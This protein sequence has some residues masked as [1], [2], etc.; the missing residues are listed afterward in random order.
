[1][2]EVL[3]PTISRALR[4]YYRGPNHPMKLRFWGWFRRAFGYAPLTVRYCER[5]WLT[6][7]ERD[8]VQRFVFTTGFYEPEVWNSL[9]TF[10]SKNEVVWDIGAHVGT[11]TIRS[12]WDSRVAAVRAFEPDPDLR[13]TLERNVRLNSRRRQICSVHGIAVAAGSRSAALYRGSVENLGLGS[14]VSHPKAVHP[15]ANPITVPCRSIDEL[16]YDDKL[17]PAS[18]MKIDVEGLESQVVRGAERTLRE[19]PPKALVIELEADGSGRATDRSLV[20]YL[21][22]LGYVLSRVPRPSGDIQPRENYL[23]TRPQ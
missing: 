19:H 20:D 22:N 11:F 16:V 18:L 8:W 3:G 9:F 21:G 4:A 5:G 14:L 1:M 15:R 10:A 12:I 7:D 2:T 17:A 6:L 13:S 23:A